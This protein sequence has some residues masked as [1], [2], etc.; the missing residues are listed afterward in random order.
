MVGAVTEP[1]LF[2]GIVVGGQTRDERVIGQRFV[3]IGA[4]VQI[5]GGR[6]DDVMQCVRIVGVVVCGG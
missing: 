2:E 4:G 5:D 1:D 6:G 3:R